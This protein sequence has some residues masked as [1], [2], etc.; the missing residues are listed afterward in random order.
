MYNILHKQRLSK[1]KRGKL[2]ALCILT[3]W[4]CQMSRMSK[5]IQKKLI[6]LFNTF[7]G[8]HVI[9]PLVIAKGVGGGTE[10]FLFFK[11]KIKKVFWFST[12]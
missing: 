1:G 12:Q 3:K 11:E 2:R 9:K 7:V 8:F 10:F 4:R 5:Q 6:S